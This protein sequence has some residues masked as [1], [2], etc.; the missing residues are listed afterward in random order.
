MFKNK[1]KIYILGI[2]CFANYES[3]AS[4]VEIDQLNNDYKFIAISEE[5]LIRKKYNYLFPVLS[6]NYCL[7]FFNL[8]TLNQVDYLVSDII[9]VKKWL[10]SGPSYNVTEFDY[11][12]KKLKLSSKKIIQ[13]N[14]H[15][16]HAASVF[17]TSG[18]KDSSILIIDGNG[19]DLETNSFYYGKNKKIKYVDSYKGRGI[20]QIYGN[21]TRDILNM[22]IGSEG[23]VMGLAPYGKHRDKNII[24]FSKVTY[25]GVISDYSSVIKRQPYTDILSLEHNIKNKKFVNDLKI[26]KKN[27][28][29]TNGIWPKIAFEVQ[30]ETERNLVKLGKNLD[31]LKLSKN[32]C[33]SGGVALNSVANNKLFNATS[34]NNISIFPACSDAGIPLGLALWG[35]HNIDDFKSPKLQKMKNAYTGKAYSEIELINI[36]KK[37]KINFKNI[38]VKEVA[39]LIA[40]QRVVG[41]YQ[42]G[43]EYGPR[44]LGNR[45]ILADSRDPKMRDYINKKI[46]HREMYRPFAPAVLEEDADKF[47]D[48]KVPSP[49]MLLVGKVKK[50]KLIPAISHVDN[51]ARVQTVNRLQNKIYYDL[52]KEFKKLTGIGCLLNTSFNDAGEPIVE[53]PLDA[54]ITFFGTDLDELIIGNIQILKNKLNNKNKSIFNKLKN[55]RSKNID[56]EYKNAIKKLFYKL[57]S[58]EKKTYIVEQ[59]NKAIYSLLKESKNF[60]NEQIK[61]LTNQNKKIIFYGT[62]DHTKFLFKNIKKLQELNIIG[63][64][65]YK[66]INEDFLDNNSKKLPIKILKNYKFKEDYNYCYIISSY[67]FAYDIEK[68]LKKSKI[69]NYY[70]I[71]SSYHKNLQESKKL[72]KLLKF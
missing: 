34:F 16:A 12:K 17:Y 60:L 7:N 57:N 62:Y 69:N 46:K 30:R 28:D 49:Y 63:F 55:Y 9:R 41:W 71:Y 53:T 10:R 48:L 36:L 37:F 58:N 42:G 61:I 26:R 72:N 1:N 2:Q 23:K 19:T 64:V 66:S 24:D 22:G 21:Y 14:H 50:P 6:I 4:I 32:I 15:L 51:T 3:G 47:F 18:F 40:N 67:E 11:F 27:Q 54:L 29:I 68:E 20:G 31:K 8:K 52:I 44:A 70:K 39:K 5:R 45:S 56:S 38:S 65:P 43:S 25:D 13:I 33:L 35:A 59:K